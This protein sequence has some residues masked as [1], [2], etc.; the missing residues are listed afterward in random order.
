MLISHSRL[1]P[2]WLSYGSPKYPGGQMQAPAPFRS[3]HSA[4]GPHGDGKHGV[5]WT[6]RSVA[7]RL[8]F[9]RMF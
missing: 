8:K 3:L 1:H 7:I 4:F 2:L 6:V 5:G 9:I